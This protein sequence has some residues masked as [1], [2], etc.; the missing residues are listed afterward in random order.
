[1]YFG[2]LSVRMIV[3]VW[4]EIN[5]SIMACDF[6]HKSFSIEKARVTL[7]FRITSNDSWSDIKERR[8]DISYHSQ[9]ST[10]VYFNGILITLPTLI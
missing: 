2:M 9:Y 3:N 4:I 1:M 5:N 6:I 10:Q 7:T 8:N